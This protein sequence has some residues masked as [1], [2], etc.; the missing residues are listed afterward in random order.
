[1]V[2]LVQVVQLVKSRISLAR[3]GMCEES[4]RE[5]AMSIGTTPT[6]RATGKPIGDKETFILLLFVHRKGCSPDIIRKWILL[7]QFWA[8]SQTKTEKRARLCP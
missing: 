7:A 4:S 3:L 1:M 5:E 8:E 6:S 2:R